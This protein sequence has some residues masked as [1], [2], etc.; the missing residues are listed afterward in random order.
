MDKLLDDLGYANKVI[1]QTD[2]EPGIMDL[3]KAVA[4]KRKGTVILQ[5]TPRYR[6]SSNGGVERFHRSMQGLAR[7]WKCAL[8][9]TYNIN[10]KA[11]DTLVKWLVRHASWIVTHYQKGRA[12]DK[13]PSSQGEEVHLG[14]VAIR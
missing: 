9:R 1:L 11:K 5:T 10:L 3:V 4:S 12:D 14:F 2:Q 13:L 6:S 8:E 7:T